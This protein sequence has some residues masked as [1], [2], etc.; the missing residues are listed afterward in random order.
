MLRFKNIWLLIGLLQVGAV[1]YLSLA[2]IEVEGP[3][4]KCIDKLFHIIAYTSLMLWFG[5]CRLPQKTFLIVGFWL[6]ILGVILELIQGTIAYRSMSSIDILANSI[7]ITLG[8]L[9]AKTP[10]VSTL[11]YLENIFWRNN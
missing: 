3:D 10:V 4:L 8:W 7:G 1:V 11:V 5:L 6:I 9:L 2:R